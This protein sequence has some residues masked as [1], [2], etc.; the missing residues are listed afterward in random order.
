MNNKLY[1]GYISRLP[2]GS[3]S[4]FSLGAYVFYYFLLFLVSLV[5]WTQS[6]YELDYMD[7][8]M[9]CSIFYALS[10][11]LIL[12]IIAICKLKRKSPIV[13]TSEFIES[14][15]KT[16]NLLDIIPLNKKLFITTHCIDNI[17]F[18]F[19]ILFF[20]IMGILA[21]P[22]GSHLIGFRG[23][24][25]LLSIAIVSVYTYDNIKNFK[26]V[27]ELVSYEKKENKVLSFIISLLP[28]TIILFTDDLLDIASVYF[29]DFFKS[30]DSFVENFIVFRFVG[31]FYV[32]FTLIALTITL[33]IY[34]NYHYIVKIKCKDLDKITNWREL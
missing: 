21:M 8:G 17:I 30:I 28:M 16:F 12:L 10:I 27:T 33:V 20:S 6:N 4:R 15:N 22:S 3:L 2:I 31:N 26:V 34:F 23:L 9:F 14:R 13:T 7:F 18:L 29:Y 25:V 1:S 32:S 24:T 11:L 19:L 5:F